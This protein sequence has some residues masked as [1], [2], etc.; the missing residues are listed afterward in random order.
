MKEGES[1]SHPTPH[2]LHKHERTGSLS[3]PHLLS[4]LQGRGESICCYSQA[5]E[6][7]P[8]GLFLERGNSICENTSSVWSGVASLG[9]CWQQDLGS[10]GKFFLES[11]VK[12]AFPVWRRREAW[13]VV[14]VGLEALHQITLRMTGLM[15][16]FSNFGVFQTHLEQSLLLSHW[17]YWYPWKSHLKCEARLTGLNPDCAQEPLGKVYNYTG[18]CLLFMNWLTSGGD[19]APIMVSPTSSPTPKKERISEPCMAIWRG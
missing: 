9:C 6:A 3:F 17:P 7:G 11:P 13:K 12:T 8:V 15:H 10:N 19:N 5:L 4:F 2:P 1:S 16:W 14:N 18:S